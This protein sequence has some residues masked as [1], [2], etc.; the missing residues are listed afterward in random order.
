M[1][2]NLSFTINSFSSSLVLL[3]DLLDGLYTSYLVTL[4]EH[5]DSIYPVH[6]CLLSSRIFC[7]SLLEINARV[8]AFSLS[9]INVLLAVLIPISGKGDMGPIISSV[10]GIIEYVLQLPVRR[11]FAVLLGY[12]RRFVDIC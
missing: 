8:M 5:F 6:V 3:F 10:Y 9:L 1:S 11:T 2:W 12:H 7:Q 4:L